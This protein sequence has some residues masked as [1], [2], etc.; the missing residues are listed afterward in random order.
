MSLGFPYETYD[1]IFII[2]KRRMCVYKPHYD[3]L[4]FRQMA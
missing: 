4:P 1:G 3:F 2:R